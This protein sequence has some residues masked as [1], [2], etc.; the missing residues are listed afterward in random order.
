MNFFGFCNLSVVP[1]RRE[2]SDKSEMTTQ[3]LFGEHFE[4]LEEYKSWVYIC[5]AIDGY[6]SWIERKQYLPISKNTFEELSGVGYSRTSDVVGVI[7]E[8][9]EDISFPVTIGSRLPFVHGKEFTIEN[10]KYNYQGNVTTPGQSQ[11]GRRLWR[12]LSFT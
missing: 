2:P 4:I 3:L 7:T 12:I 5:S 11:G 10:K 8:I 6:K 9:T 1:C